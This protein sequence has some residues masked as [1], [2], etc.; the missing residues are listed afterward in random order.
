MPSPL[1]RQV[2]RI[3]VFSLPYLALMVLGCIWLAERNY[4][5][6]FVSVTA[7]F[8]IAGWLSIGWLAAKPT[9]RIAKPPVDT[10]PP[11]GEHAW[12][13]VN[14]IAERVENQPPPFGDSEAYLKLCREV[15]DSVAKHFYPQSNLPAYEITV[16]QAMELMERV[17]RD[18]RTMLEEQVP[19]SDQLTV[20]NIR[21]MQ[22]LADWLPAFRKVYD[23]GYGLYRVARFVR[24]PISATISEAQAHITG[25]TSST[26]LADL[27][28]MAAGYCVQRLG[29]YAIQLYSGQCQLDL[30][31]MADLGADKPLRILLLG[32]AKAGKS[33]LVNALFGQARASTDVLPCTMQT[34]EYVIERAGLPSALVLDTVGFGGSDDAAARAKLDEELARSDVIMVVTSVRNAA[35]EPDRLLLDEARRRYSEQTKRAAPPVLVALTHADA[36]RPFQEWSP[37]YDF[38]HGDRPKERNVRDAVEAVAQD[39]QVSAENIVPVCLK[40]G[41][42]YNVDEGLVAALARR[43]PEGER[44]KLLRILMDSRSGAD[45]ERLRQQLKNLGI[46][47]LSAFGAA[48]AKHLRKQS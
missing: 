35:R 24:N 44:A 16:P 23:L 27:P 48:G 7:I 31:E 20:R 5:L 6:Y 19:L 38:V 17:A 29:F 33:S 40:E 46:N 36:V 15:V 34:V 4:L 26:L 30:P 1:F 10:W 8:S 21:D 12:V 14:K 2:L 47:I 9:A 25:N 37:P 41:A 42:V 18:F 39:L 11:A 32:Q 3:G 28:G 13:D 43:L 22:K 45:S